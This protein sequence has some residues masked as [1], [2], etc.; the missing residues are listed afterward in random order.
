MRSQS[1]GHV[2][3]VQGSI[4]R[5]RDEPRGHVGIVGD[6]RLGGLHVAEDQQPVRRRVADRAG[7]LQ[8]R[9]RTGRPG[10]AP[11]APGGAPRAARRCRRR[12]RNEGSAGFSARRD[13]SEY[14][15][16][17]A[18]L[19]APTTLQ[20]AS[21]RLTLPRRTL[22]AL[23]F[24]SGAIA[25]VL[26]IDD[27]MPLQAV[28]F[29]LVGWSFVA[30]GCVA[31]SRRPEN[32]VGALMVV[33][34]LIWFVS[35]S[36]APLAGAAAADRRHLARRPVAA[37]AGL[38][39]GRLP[40]GAPARHARARPDR[41]ARARD[42]PARV[43]VAAV[44]ELR[45]LRRRAGRQRADDRRPARDRGGRRH[46]PARDPDRLPGHAGRSSSCDAGS[47]PAHRCG[48]CCSRCWPV[49]PAW[50]C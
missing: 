25:I 28:L 37:A 21:A 46:R 3:T 1:A 11:G 24:A 19:H 15:R 49:R 26:A 23:A 8:A 4:D 13:S 45:V 30:S 7:D 40:A 32:H 17:T 39:A 36:A 6:E 38:P 34:G 5:A 18:I 9:R 16:D 35:Q 27:G 47:T 14:C 10:S 43:P 20:P 29:L 42:D 2:T 12:T 22:I 33:I 41:R 44:P 50:R 48:A 31:W